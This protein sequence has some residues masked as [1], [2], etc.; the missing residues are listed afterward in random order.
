MSTT[1]Y[2]FS[3]LVKGPLQKEHSRSS[4]KKIR[5][6]GHNSVEL[7]ACDSGR[8]EIFDWSKLVQMVMSVVI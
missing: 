1:D 6:S 3:D 5:K 8:K 2:C 4:L 7:V